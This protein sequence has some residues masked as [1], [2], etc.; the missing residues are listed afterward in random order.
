MQVYFAAAGLD[1]IEE[2]EDINPRNK[3]KVKAGRREWI[4]DFRI[5]K[6]MKDTLEHNVDTDERMEKTYLGDQGGQKGL[7][8][9]KLVFSTG[10][11]QFVQWLEG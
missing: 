8:R 5:V 4:F 3:L 1:V 6:A 10:A 7:K 9:V 11:R 2:P